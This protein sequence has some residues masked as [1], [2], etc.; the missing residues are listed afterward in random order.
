MLRQAQ[1]NLLGYIW[2]TLVLSDYFVQMAHLDTIS[3]VIA[4]NYL[5]TMLPCLI[6]LK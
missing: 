1:E 2:G 4:H 3:Q 5:K 6:G